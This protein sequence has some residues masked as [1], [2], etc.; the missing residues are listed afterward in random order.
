MF[1]DSPPNL[2][3]SSPRCWETSVD[4]STDRP[5]HY[6]KRGM[7][8]LRAPSD[9]P[10]SAFASSLYGLGCWKGAETPNVQYA[11]WDEG[12]NRGTVVWGGLVHNLR[13]I[14]RYTFDVGY[15]VVAVRIRS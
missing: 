2:Y 3:H 8:G 12:G 6:D 10:A 14:S 5:L 13:Q 1:I 9:R 15:M 7:T 11:K 4:P